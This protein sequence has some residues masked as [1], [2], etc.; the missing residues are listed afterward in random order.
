MA[1]RSTKCCADR[2][3]GTATA[4]RYSCA[5]AYWRSRRPPSCNR[6]RSPIL[7]SRH[8]RACRDSL[9]RSFQCGQVWLR[10]VVL[11][12][13]LIASLVLVGWLNQQGRRERVA[14]GLTNEV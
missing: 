4:G 8:L 6:T 3:W 9:A 11:V 5:P 10:V 2:S 12:V 7:D 1:S 14:L 13:L